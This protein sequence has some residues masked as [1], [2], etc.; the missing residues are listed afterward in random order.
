MNGVTVGGYNMKFKKCSRCGVEKPLNTDF[1]HRSKKD[2]KT[3]FKSDCKKCRNTYNTEY[4]KT[5]YKNNR[6]K[7]RDYYKRGKM[8]EYMREYYKKNRNKAINRSKDYYK[9]NK[10]YVRMKTSERNR[11]EE[12]RLY[13]RMKYHKRISKM[14]KT[15]YTFT[16]E[17]WEACKKYF[18]YSCAY[19]G[20]EGVELQQEHFIPVSKDGEYSRR[21]IVPSCRSCNSKKHTS[22]FDEW[23]YE[24]PFYDEERESKILKYLNYNNQKQQ[25]EMF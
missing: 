23:Y 19:C 6:K 2:N 21:N 9:N 4:S 22:Y 16:P 25:M 20:S 18:N 15:I 14:K 3:G 12:G 8:R 13:S 11:T 7:I 1:F 10:D 17:Q 24:Q 5:Y